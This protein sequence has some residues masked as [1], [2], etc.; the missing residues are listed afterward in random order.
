LVTTTMIPRV[1]TRVCSARVL[2]AKVRRFCAGYSARAD[3]G[4][5]ASTLPLTSAVWTVVCAVTP[6]VSTQ[7]P[8]LL[9][10]PTSVML[11]GGTVWA[12]DTPG[13]HHKTPRRNSAI[14]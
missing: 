11:I 14:S 7:T 12:N 13:E 9:F 8:P 1:A 3:D 2:S 6:T 4:Y 10:S 5:V